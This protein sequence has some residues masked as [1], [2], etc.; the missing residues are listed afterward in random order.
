M[1]KTDLNLWNRLVKLKGMTTDDFT[2]KVINTY[3]LTLQYGT[4]S[5]KEALECDSFLKQNNV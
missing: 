1:L 3:L 5:N 2:K 4:M